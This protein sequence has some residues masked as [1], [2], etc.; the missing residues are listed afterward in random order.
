MTIPS[1]GP[2]R[3]PRADA[4]LRQ[5][6]VMGPPDELTAATAPGWVLASRWKGSPSRRKKIQ[7]RGRKI[8]VGSFRKSN[9]SRVNVRSAS[10]ILAARDRQTGH[11]A[12]ACAPENLRPRPRGILCDFARRP[13]STFFDGGRRGNRGKSRPAAEAAIPRS[14]RRAAPRS[15]PRA[16]DRARSPCGRGA[17]WRGPAPA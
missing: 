2:R 12:A 17:T 3:I 14:S 5:R 1:V 6:S 8:Q 16:P 10:K 4:R 9:L 11:S 7:A 15:P 13:R